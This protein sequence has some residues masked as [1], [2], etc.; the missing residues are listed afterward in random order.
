MS[1]GLPIEIKPD[2]K[3]P[4]KK[5]DEVKLDNSASDYDKLY[6]GKTHE[7]YKNLYEAELKKGK[8]TNQKLVEWLANKIQ[9]TTPADTEKTSALNEVTNAIVANTENNTGLKVGESTDN[10]P[11]PGIKPTNVDDKRAIGAT[12]PELNTLYE[13]G[14]ISEEAYRKRLAEL[15][16]GKAAENE[17]DDIASGTRKAEETLSEAEETLSEGDLVDTTDNNTDNN[18][19]VT[20]EIVEEADPVTKKRYAN[21]TMGIWDAYRNKAIDLGTAMYFTLDAISNFARNTGKDI[22][23]IAAAFSGGT[24]DNS[25]RS[26]SMWQQR[27]DAMFENEL[28]SE[29]ESDEGSRAWRAAQHDFNSLTSEQQNIVAKNIE[30]WIAENSK[31]LTVEGLQKQLEAMGYNNLALKLNTM[32]DEDLINAYKNGNAVE[33][34]IAVLGRAVQKGVSANTPVGSFSFGK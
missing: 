17:A 9:E 4:G 21:T 16:S 7:E 22:G 20:E 32:M 33:K 2:M 6:G 14:Q 27:R 25:D 15:T 1:D 26:K 23:N 24:M 8:K 11:K 3:K 28:G 29:L 31:H 19:S 5:L 12:L 34:V 13:Q 18:N 30:N 10:T